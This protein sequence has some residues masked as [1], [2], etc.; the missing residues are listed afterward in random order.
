MGPYPL[1]P[2]SKYYAR[3]GGI[4]G[5]HESATFPSTLQLY[6]YNFTF[7]T[8]RLSYLDSE[9]WESRTDGAIAFAPLPAGPS[10]FTQEFADM[11]FTCRGDLQ[12]AD[13]PASSGKKHLAYWN[14]DITPQ[15]IQF[16][17]TSADTCG[18]GA[19][20]LVLGV[21]TTLPFIPQAVHA[22]LGFRPNGNLVTPADGVAG[23]DSRFEVPA[24]LSLQGPGGDIFP[25]STVAKGY[26]NNWATA[27]APASGFFNLAGTLRVPFFT[28]IKVHLHIAPTGPTNAQIAIMGG[29]PAANS[30]AADLGWTVSG[31]NYFNTSTFDSN[32]DGWP[33]AQVSLN[34]Y[35]NSPTTQYRPRAQRD[36]I[37]VAFFDYPLQW[38]PALRVFAGFQDAQVILPVI[39][40]NSR[41]K[42]I[43]PGKVDFD[44]AQ[45]VTLQL[46]QIKALDF[47]NDAVNEL[48]GP[49]L[50]VS[51]AVRGALGAALDTSGLN[52]LQQ[53]LREDAQS[54]FQTA[55]DT[56]LNPVAAQIYNQIASYPQNDPAAFSSNVVYQVNN[57]SLSVA[58]GNL[59]GAVG[60][61][62]SVLGQLDTTLNDVQRDLGV[63]LQVLAKDSSGNRHVIN[64]V[65]EQLA[66]DQGPALGFVGSL[67]DAEVNTLVTNLN[68]TLDAIQSQLLDVSNQIGQ[69]HAQLTGGV[70]GFY[71]ALSEPFSD[72]NAVG[73]FVQGAAT[74]L[75]NLFASALTPAGDYFSANPNAARQAIE[76]Q[77]VAAFLSS[78]LAS[79]YQQTLRQFL[80]D[81]NAALDELMDTLFDQINGA[82]R[83]ALADQITGA[84]D[85]ALQAVKGLA[86]G[87]FLSAKIRG[88]PTFNGDSLRKIHL[89]AAIQ[90][91]L[92]DPMNF[93]A[94]MEILE[95]DSQS[96]P[97][98]CVPAG[99]PAAEVTLGATNVKLDW[100]GLNPSGV[101]LTLGVVAKWTVQGGNVIGL[102]G[103]FD[104]KG[105]VGFQGCSVNEIGAAVAFGAT[106]NYF[107]AKA[108]GTILIIGIPVDVQAG[109]FVG[110]ACSLD[111]LTFIDPAANDVL[112]GHAVEFN[113][114]YV[115]FGAGLSLS[116]ILF[117]GSS[118][119][120]D[121]EETETT[122]V[123]YNGGP[124][125][126]QVGMRQQ[127]ALD[128]SL[129]CL[130]SG[131]ASL[132]M[133]GSVTHSASG[134]EMDL[135]GSAQLCGSL[136]PCPFCISGCKGITVTGVVNTGGIDYSVDY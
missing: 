48:D 46:P 91:N 131:S 112:G 29:W 87:S 113:G 1:T 49:L 67:A 84:Q 107:A 82:I 86:S 68:P 136:G 97:L 133:F 33:A 25:L 132:T 11:V 56:Q 32:S 80:F 50:S 57:S 76:Q 95:L 115:E 135:G 96:V 93:N 74:D 35:E 105:K 122:A 59:N 8:Y 13:V 125:T 69:V 19:R 103:S 14:M 27:G 117:G 78:A 23:T 102:G 31:N 18:T 85:G 99:A 20:W 134:F 40:V 53:T 5:I 26:F 55:L 65:I 81:P 111:P 43:S 114:L 116:D 15:S 36:W 77:L 6:G 24:Q 72:A 38:N 98:D 89:D 92:P 62:G 21:Q 42:E 100:P 130:I 2:R 126:Q 10:G 12:S 17:P 41:L 106:E 16:K 54:F 37:E 90:V 129:A 3:F 22:A 71:Q 66:S 123:F 63:L 4:S 34:D 121:V 7:T 51:N 79:D 127:V 108:A 28:D 58:V 75:T 94:F 45:D 30:E 128:L 73:Q 109:V 120:L 104:I 52:E 83:D 9:V 101:P 39:N 70:G 64:A 119:F 61:A 124:S 88:S 47:L 118:C 110:K 44:F 60:Q